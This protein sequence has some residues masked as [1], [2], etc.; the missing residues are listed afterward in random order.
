MQRA[1]GEEVQVDVEHGLPRVRVAVEHG[2]IPAL[3]ISV[4]RR[5]LSGHAEHRPDQL[6]VGR[7]QIVQRADVPPGHNQGVERRLW[8]D[9]VERVELLAPGAGRRVRRRR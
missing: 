3:C 8:I 7:L 9:V 4:L 5:K 1:P 6:I 2:A